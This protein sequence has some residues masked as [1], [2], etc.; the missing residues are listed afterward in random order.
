MTW[1]ERLQKMRQDA[2]DKAF[3]LLME[4]HGSEKIDIGFIPSVGEEWGQIVISRVDWC[5]PEGFQAGFQAHGGMTRDAVFKAIYDASQ[6]WPII[7]AN[8]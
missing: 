1:K 5:R 2:T 6:R 8:D 7:G 4:T 3:A